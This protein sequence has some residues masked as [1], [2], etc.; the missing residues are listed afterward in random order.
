MKKRNK[1]NIPPLEAI[2]NINN[3][4]PD[5][6]NEIKKLEPY[7]E[8]YNWPDWC[9]MPISMV[10]NMLY[11]HYRMDMSV[12]SQVG[13]IS[14]LAGWRRYKSVFQFDAELV[15]ELK[16][17]DLNEVIP[18]EVFDMMPYPYIFLQMQGINYGALVC[19]E[20][21]LDHQWAELRM[22]ILGEHGNLLG[23]PI[24]HLKGGTLRQNF[25]DTERYTQE[26]MKIWPGDKAS[27]EIN[28]ANNLGRKLT[29]AFLPLVLYLCTVNAE[30]DDPVS[31]TGEARK[32]QLGGIMTPKDKAGEVTIFPVGEN[33]G[34]RIREYKADQHKKADVEPVPDD[35]HKLTTGAVPS[36]RS[37]HVRRGHYHHYW[38]GSKTKGTRKL[39]LKWT[40]PIFIHGNSDH[41]PL[42]TINVIR[43]A[44]EATKEKIK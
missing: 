9:Y 7:K 31:V 32:V 16:K 19:R 44:K 4:F 23:M 39:I 20:Y 10:I 22:Y 42:V 3:Q 43:K 18:I 28:L 26:N 8:I 33:I 36:K 40:A 5:I 1:I 15:E 13:L 41:E 17:T 14:A 21:D 12:M 37:P 30:I 2:R 38:T 35:K 29:R 34:V 6:W 25:E 27:K 24:L 11:E